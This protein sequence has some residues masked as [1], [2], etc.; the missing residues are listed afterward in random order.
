MVRSTSEDSSATWCRPRA[1]L[2]GRA[3]LRYLSRSR[4][5]SASMRSRSIAV[6]AR[7]SDAEEHVAEPLQYR[8]VPAV[9]AGVGAAVRGQHE[10]RRIELDHVVKVVDVAGGERQTLRGDLG[11]RATG[12][13]A[14]GD[15]DP[16]GERLHPGRVA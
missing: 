10:R 13:G 7:P 9:G 1:L 15:A 14:G 3:S 12:V 8:P 2:A 5:R 11:T 6:I 4:C 16:D